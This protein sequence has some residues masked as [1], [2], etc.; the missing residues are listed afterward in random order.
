LKVEPSGAELLRV[1]RETLLEELLPRLPAENHYAA[2]MVANAMAIAAR[3]LEGAAGD[4]AAEIAR[5]RALLPEW[6]PAGDMDA[7][8]REANAKLAAAVRAGRFDTPHAQ[9]ELFGHLRKSTE[10]R[11][12]V[13]AP[14]RK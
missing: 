11:L 14:R 12:A 2:R 1:A 4:P 5:V 9:A 13:S 10:E 6:A 8:V 3:E 7:Q